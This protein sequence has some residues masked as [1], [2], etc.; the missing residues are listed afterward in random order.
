MIRAP[1]Q[2]IPRIVLLLLA[3]ATCHSIVHAQVAQ[4]YRYERAHKNSDDYFHIISLK[5]DGLA[6]F[7]ERDKYKQSNRIWELIF[8][9]SA[10]QEKKTLELEI[11]ERNKMVGY[12]VTPGHIYFLFRAGETTKNDFELLDITFDGVEAGRFQVKPDLD[13]RLTHFIKAGDNFVFGGYVSNEAVIIMFDPNA[14]SIKVLPGFFQKDT[15]LVDLKT[16]QNNTFN[17]V[18]VDRSNRGEKKLLFRTFDETGKQLLED[19]VTLDDNITLQTGISS[20][21]EREDLVIAGTWGDRNS[22]QSSGFYIV[23]VNPFEDQKIRFIDFGQLDRFTDYLSPKR[24]AKIK[25]LSKESATSGRKPAFSSYVMPFKIVESK[26]GFYLL[27]EVYQPSSSSMQTA[28]P[29]YYNPYY[30]PYGY[31]PFYRGF[32]YPAMSRMYRPYMYGPNPRTS[33]EVRTLETAVLLFD[34]KGNIKWDQSV[35]LDEVRL[36]AL[37]QVGDFVVIDQEIFL[38]YKKESEIKIKSVA[39]DG[40]DANESAHKI[41]TGSEFDVIRSEKQVEGGVRYWYG[42]SFYVYGYQTIRNTTKQDRVRDVFY[43]N[44]IDP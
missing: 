37:E 11:R 29:Y 39:L 44:R 35:K 21:L 31:Y 1:F 2:S 10:L 20:S 13:F 16:N 12:E 7:R 28:N 18:L 36:P 19:N 32:Y 6:L 17:T 43:I 27:A 41:K 34:E 38:V 26:E 3:M 40:G 14:N 25:A 22:K 9:D 23:P 15:E 42:E 5:Q 33:D 8:L 24:A 30:N 4:P